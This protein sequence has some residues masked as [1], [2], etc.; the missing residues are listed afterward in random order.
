MPSLPNPS[1]L[2]SFWA[3]LGAA[4]GIRHGLSDTLT[5]F[6][7]GFARWLPIVV[8]AP[9]L[10]GGRSVVNAVKLGLGA[11]L[12]A[13]MVPLLSAGAP[14]PLGL[15]GLVWWGIAVREICVGL[16]LGFAGSLL[17]W[18]AEIG[19]RFIDTSRGANIAQAFVPQLAT[20]SSPLGSFF[21]QLF[22]ALFYT[23]GG[24]RL[25]FDAV[26]DSYRLI[27]V[28][29]SRLS[30]GDVT[31]ELIA[32][33]AGTF[34]LG[35]KI[36]APA[37]LIIVLLDLVLGVAN[38]MAP[39]LDVFFFSLSLRST[40]ASAVIAISLYYV[41]AIVTDATQGEHARLAEILSKLGTRD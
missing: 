23:L 38:R 30:L 40:L 22:V 41:V 15:S 13:F 33:T 21:Y 34:V 27:P 19:G 3:P 16:L 12:A 7:L 26:F 31:G 24:H 1:I 20:Q 39:Q 35:L 14:V 5:L 8:V 4:A 29:S 37:M 25:F 11:L 10:G 17:F 36:V 9:F 28:V 18:G 6:L 32:G 2:E